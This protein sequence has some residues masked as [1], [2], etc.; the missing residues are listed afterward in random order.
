MSAAE[1]ALQELGFLSLPAKPSAHEVASALDA[2]AA[3]ATDGT[4]PEPAVLQELGRGAHKA[5]EERGVLEAA[6]MVASALDGWPTKAH[7]P[8][9]PEPKPLPLDALPKVLQDMARTSHEAT[10]APLDSAIGAV[11]GGVSVAIVGKVEVEI[12]AD[13]DWRKPAHEYIGIQQPSGTGKSPLINMVREAYRGVG[14]EEGQRG[15]VHPQ[16]GGR[17]DQVGREVC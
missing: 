2:L 8:G 10:Q 16:V 5:L 15:G 17:T 1:V 13:T 9:T 14:G 7:E 12:R 11:L 4:T 6:P 3:L